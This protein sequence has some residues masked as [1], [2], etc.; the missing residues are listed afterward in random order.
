MAPLLSPEL[1][2]LPSILEHAVRARNSDLII[3]VTQDPRMAVSVLHRA[4]I[5][6]LT[7]VTPSNTFMDNP[8]PTANEGQRIISRARGRHCRLPDG[9]KDIVGAASGGCGNAGAA[10]GLQITH[11]LAWAGEGRHIGGR[12]GGGTGSWTGRRDDDPKDLFVAAL[13]SAYIHSV[14]AGGGVWLLV[15]I[16]LG[17]V[18]LV[19]L[20]P[21]SIDRVVVA[22]FTTSS[23]VGEG[24]ECLDDGGC[25]GFGQL[26][27]GGAAR[28]SIWRRSGSSG[29]DR[30]WRSLE[31]FNRIEGQ[32]VGERGLRLSLRQSSGILILVLMLLR[33][34]S[35]KIVV[36]VNTEPQERES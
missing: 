29:E 9:E 25:G 18:C 26:L 1:D 8:P 23:K 30:G 24:S 4:Q 21:A 14:F 13:S 15:L 17:D 27:E 28:R 7:V 6:D 35:R 32:T 5:T 3:S 2:V 10:A 20:S 34:C 22:L 36:L 12:G 31:P 11:A 19:V 16:T 33:G